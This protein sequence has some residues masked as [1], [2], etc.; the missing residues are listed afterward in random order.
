MR[1]S[2]YR[3]HNS[4][5]WWDTLYIQLNKF[6]SILLQVMKKIREKKPINV[7]VSVTGFEVWGLSKTL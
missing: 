4:V 2:K 5:S 7:S 1:N 6:I 3:K